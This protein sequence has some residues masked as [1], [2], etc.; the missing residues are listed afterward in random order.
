MMLRSMTATASLPASRSFAS[1][2]I[3]ESRACVVTGFLRGLRWEEWNRTAAQIKVVRSVWHASEGTTKTEQSN[4]F[5]TVTD[6]SREILLDLWKSQGSPL[7][8]YSGA[9]QG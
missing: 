4:R 8:G 6:E 3:S 5:V 9:C 7:G 2:R 1:S